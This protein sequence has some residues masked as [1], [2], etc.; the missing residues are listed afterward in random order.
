MLLH[1]GLELMKYRQTQETGRDR[2]VAG[3]EP[4]ARRVDPPA[5]RRSGAISMAGLNKRSNLGMSKSPAAKPE[6][7]EKPGKPTPKPKPKAR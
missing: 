4:Q 7:P 1:R 2:R 5:R 6:K 3:L